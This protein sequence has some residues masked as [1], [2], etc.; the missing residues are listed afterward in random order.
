MARGVVSVMREG[1]CPLIH[2]ISDTMPSRITPEDSLADA[3]WMLT[4]PS[5]VWP[6]MTTE[7]T[8]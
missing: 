2:P 6:C 4:V 8:P 7:L 3:V 5:D 1:H